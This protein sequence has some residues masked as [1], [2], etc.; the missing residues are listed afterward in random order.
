MAFCPHCGKSVTDQ[1]SKCLACGKE[2]EPRAKAAR[3]KGTMMMTPAVRPQIPAAPAPE[4][5][6]PAKASPAAAA[7][8]APLAAAP[9]PTTPGPSKVA[10]VTMLGTGGMG[11]AP[12]R[13]AGAPGSGP[14]PPPPAAAAAPAPAA[15]P[16]SAAPAQQAPSA[17]AA[18][19]PATPDRAIPDEPSSPAAR[20]DSQRFLVG[21][22]MAPTGGPAGSTARTGKRVSGDAVQD[23]VPQHKTPLIIGVAMAGMAVIAAIGYA[24]ARLMGLLN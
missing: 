5:A 19:E 23:Q 12:P 20:E 18:P 13:P 14:K 2:F 10:K 3:M 6:A 15:T 16:A 9:R 24:T 8:A 4:P 11:L 1:A 7:P 17:A 22:P 21:D